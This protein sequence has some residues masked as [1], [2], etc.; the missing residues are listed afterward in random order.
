MQFCCGLVLV[1][2]CF[3]IDLWGLKE[4]EKQARAG[5]LLTGAAARPSFIH[6]FIRSFLHVRAHFPTA[7]SDAILGHKLACCVGMPP[8]CDGMRSFM[9][10]KNYKRIC[11]QLLGK[12]LQ[13]WQNMAG[14]C[15]VRLFS[16]CPVPVRLW[17]NLLLSFFRFFHLLYS[18]TKFCPLFSLWKALD[19]HSFPTLL[20][21]TFSSCVGLSWSFS[22]SVFMHWA[23]FTP[24]Q[25][26]D[27]LSFLCFQLQWILNETSRHLGFPVNMEVSFDGFRVFIVTGCSNRLLPS[28]CSDNLSLKR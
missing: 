18:D 5:F 1:W 3:G 9:L 15:F 20:S 14:I 21:S 10:R 11:F 7:F 4:S 22:M 23:L 17:A 26:F 28:C 6:S 19:F 12:A 13:K 24:V 2:L 27:Y 25:T 8:V 16:A